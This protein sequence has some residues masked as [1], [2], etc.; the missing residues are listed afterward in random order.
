MILVCDQGLC[1]HVYAAHKLVYMSRVYISTYMSA[2]VNNALNR[3]IRF[4][5]ALLPGA[6]SKSI[7]G[8]AYVTTL[9]AGYVVAGKL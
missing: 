1:Q 3:R 4:W 5:A 2:A 9:H 7:V 8:F 6:F